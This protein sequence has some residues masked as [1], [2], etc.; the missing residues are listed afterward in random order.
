M[1]NNICEIE[2]TYK[3]K[4]KPSERQKLS[5]SMD[6]YKIFN[7]IFEANGKIEYKEIMYALFL[8]RANKVLGVSLISEGGT[9]GTVCDPKMIFQ[10]ALKANA[11]SFI[12]CHNHPS[13]N[14]QPSNV[15]ISLTKKIKTLGEMMEIKILDHIILCPDN[16]F[17]SMSN[18]GL[19]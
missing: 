7:A 18:E 8:N 15:D 13:G 4:V 17:L 16:Q 9:S 1:Q 3:S 6:A 10:A 12:L 5:S 19:I 11:S 2:I 14:L